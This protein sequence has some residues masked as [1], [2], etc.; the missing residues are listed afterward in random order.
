MWLLGGSQE[1]LFEC[2][3]QRSIGDASILLVGSSC[4]DDSVAEGWDMLGSISSVPKDRNPFVYGNFSGHFIDFYGESC[5]KF[6]LRL[7]DPPLGIPLKLCSGFRI[8]CLQHH[9]EPSIRSSLG[10]NNRTECIIPSYIYFSL[11]T[12]QFQGTVFRPRVPSD[13]T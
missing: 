7:V 2:D 9:R 13:A 8:P 5:F 3:S 12:E 6:T 11:Y 1:E 4:D 10:Q